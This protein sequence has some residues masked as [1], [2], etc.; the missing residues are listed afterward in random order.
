[1][2]NLQIFVHPVFGEIRILSAEG[3][4]YACSEDIVHALNYPHSSTAIMQYCKHPVTL[5]LQ[6]SDRT[7][8]DILCIG[9]EDI[10]RLIDA[11]SSEHD[12]F[13][14]WF[15]GTVLPCAQR[16]INRKQPTRTFSYF[17]KGKRRSDS[18]RSLCKAADNM[19]SQLKEYRPKVLFSLAVESSPDSIPIGAFAKLLCQNGFKIGRK[20]LFCRLRNE[21]YLMK[22]G[23]DYNLPT[24]K[25]I[26]LGLFELSEQIIYKPDGTTR[27]CLSTRITGKG[28]TYLLNKWLTSSI[29]A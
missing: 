4:C 11:A 28:Q 16:A 14:C 1:M 2:K 7:V 8:R 29:S 12:A 15:F 6:D 26:E 17:T 18:L 22:S 9:C 19:R 24:Q 13:A 27:F 5:T 21:G 25:S 23:E 10:H 20:R 3:V